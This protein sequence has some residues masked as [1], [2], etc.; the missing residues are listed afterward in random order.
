M[1]MYSES[2]RPSAFANLASARSSDVGARNFNSS[3]HF[4]VIGDSEENTARPEGRAANAWPVV[5][6]AGPD[7]HAG[8]EDCDHSGG[9][10]GLL[11]TAGGNDL[12]DLECSQLWDVLAP[13]V[14][15]RLRNAER[16]GQRLD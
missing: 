8:G 16:F 15:C 13:L 12:P 7:C 1:R 10:L 9:F 5:R 3:V 4:S 14:D 6:V 11:R 2:E